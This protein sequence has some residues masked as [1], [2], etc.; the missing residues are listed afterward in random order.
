M[1]SKLGPALTRRLETSSPDDRLDVQ[2]LLRREPS[3]PW[4]PSIESGGTPDKQ[5]VAN[6]ADQAAQQNFSRFRNRIDPLLP[7]GEDPQASGFSYQELW[8]HWINNSLGARVSLQALEQILEFPDVDF[9][10]LVPRATLEDVL[11]GIA[12]PQP[13]DF[14]F[15]AGPALAPQV[16]LVGAAGL[17]PALR[18]AR[19]LV[20][21][22][23]TGI[24]FGHPDLARRGW[25]GGVAFP[26]HGSNFEISG[27][28]PMDQNGHGTRS[29]GVIAGD[30][31]SGLTTGIAP[32]ATLMA[33]RVGA[34]ENHVW[35]AFEF[36][37]VHGADIISLSMGWNSLLNPN[38]E[39]WRRACE[40]L[41]K[42]GI[43]LVC[44]A[45]NDGPQSG[46]PPLDVPRN[47]SAPAVCPP[48]WLHPV[49]RLGRL[50]AAMAC[51]ETNLQDCPTSGSSHG[52]GV[53][54]TVPFDDYPFQGGQQG[55]VKPDLCGPGRGSMTCNPGF[56]NS[57]QPLYA[58]YSQTS[59]SAAVVSGCAALLVDAAKQ[60][61][62]PV[63]PRRIQQALETGA[64]PISGQTT[65]QNNL[66][67]G[68]VDVAAAYHFGVAQGWW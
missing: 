57:G 19:T 55:I 23:D 41:L 34:S 9:V 20:A 30:G 2:I 27:Q 63:L 10:E 28:P 8:S 32:E 56:R 21:V 24:D 3:A 45:G 54:D 60:S 7:Q 14:E 36:A 52:P 59:A 4:D 65:K 22:V 64:V 1:S 13:F 37:T 35:S 26:G 58:P 18:G 16:Q 48:P 40:L 12:E 43:L 61:G 6:E 44:S 47:I 31:S 42:A 53:W 49:Q 50:S 38:Y 33:L 25:P 68:R 11:H 51:G 62:K 67:S 46:N 29:A 5:A 66:G 17:G 39:G 15:L